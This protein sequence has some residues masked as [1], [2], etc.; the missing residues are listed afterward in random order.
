MIYIFIAIACA[1]ITFI[2]VSVNGD[3]PAKGIVAFIFGLL[4]VSCFIVFFIHSSNFSK[5]VEIVQLQLENYKIENDDLTVVINDKIEHYKL[6]EYKIE[7]YYS[8]E[9]K[10]VMKYYEASWETFFLYLSKDITI[11]SFDI[12]TNTL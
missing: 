2:L 11:V 5:N 12:Y 8:E 4:C 9:E 10:L 3:H 6:S 1:V 7:T